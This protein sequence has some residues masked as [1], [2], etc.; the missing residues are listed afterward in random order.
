MH[1]ASSISY[2]HGNYLHC[3]VGCTRCVGLIIFNNFSFG[4]LPDRFQLL[5]C[6]SDWSK[7]F[8]F[9]CIV[10]RNCKRIAL[11]FPVVIRG[12]L[13]AVGVT[14]KCNLIW[15]WQIPS[16]KRMQ[17]QTTFRN[18]PHRQGMQSGKLSSFDLQHQSIKYIG[19]WEEKHYIR[20]ERTQS[21]HSFVRASTSHD[22]PISINQPRSSV[23]I[24]RLRIRE[25]SW[26][27]SPHRVGN[28]HLRLQLFARK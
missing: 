21:V 6:C 14:V 23:S 27:F 8:E 26:K 15:K 5:Q 16:W 1:L 25:W 9:L 19:F 20:T 28:F 2:L 12:R 13:G 4:L 11:G 3:V 22:L 24:D 10:S 18:R 17:M 7:R